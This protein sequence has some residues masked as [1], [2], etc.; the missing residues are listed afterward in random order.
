M[1]TA[2]EAGRPQPQTTVDPNAGGP[3]IRY[4]QPGRGPMYVA[5]N[6]MGT[7]ITNPLVA[8]PGYLSRFRINHTLVTGGTLTSAVLSADAPYD[9]VQQIFLKDA[10]GTVLFT[11][12]GYDIAYLVGL[13]GGGW[14]L[15]YNA[16]PANLP[17]Y[18]AL[19]ATTGAGS[20]SYALPLEYA[21]G[22][23]LMSAAN[24]S[25]VPQLNI[26]LSPFATVFGA[27]TGTAPTVTTTVDADYYWLP[28][29]QSILPPGLGSTR[30][31]IT[32]NA[33]PTISASSS[34]RVQFPRLGGYLDTI[35]MEFRDSTGARTDG[36]FPTGRFQFFI[37]GVPYLD[38]SMEELEDDMAIQFGFDSANTRPTGT[39][40]ISRKTS[41]SQSSL[42]LLDTGEQYLSTSPATLVEALI[43][44][45]GA[46]TN[47]P[48][49]MTV[50]V[51]QI[52]PTGSMIFGLAEQ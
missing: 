6:A 12:S 19:S 15:G 8:K 39:L 34:T 16:N 45:A 22:V 49:T 23:G 27:G 13:Y 40:A 25:L 1:A 21:K 43:A 2:Q 18:A 11:G 35:V 17:S 44:P 28:E 24:A 51:G 41:L 52:V 3:F 48:A 47:S 33:N 36:F 31:W 7:L 20:Y 32:V 26:T 42:G 29:G 38:S 14:G 4:A 30:Q 5:N 46:G 10:F 37:D 50:L 9:V